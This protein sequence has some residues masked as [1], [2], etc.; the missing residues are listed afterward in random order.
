MHA[1]YKHYCGFGDAGKFRGVRVDDKRVDLA[2]KR[3]TLHSYS[4]LIGKSFLS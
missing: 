3:G 2:L 4:N 1:N